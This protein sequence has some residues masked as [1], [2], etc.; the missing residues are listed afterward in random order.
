MQSFKLSDG[1]TF[2]GII[3]KARINQDE[4]R[5]II[6]LRC[7]PKDAR[8]MAEYDKALRI[9]EVLLRDFHDAHPELTPDELEAAFDAYSPDKD[10]SSSSG[11]SSG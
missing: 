4:L 8:V 10:A 3:T 1:R 7:T 2:T 11:V 9:K 6:V 5:D